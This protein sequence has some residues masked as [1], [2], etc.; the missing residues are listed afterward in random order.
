M[1]DFKRR[2]RVQDSK[3]IID[4]PDEFIGKEIDVHIE[5]VFKEKHNR[6]SSNYL[7]ELLNSP[8]PAGGFKIWKREEIYG[9]MQNIR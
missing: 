7:K 3:L 6:N 9:H 5:L 8:I 2:M 1:N 4:L